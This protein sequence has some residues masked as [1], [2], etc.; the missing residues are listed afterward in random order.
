MGLNVRAFTR[1]HIVAIA[2]GVL[3]AGTPLIAFN[4]WLGG[5]IE[6]QGQAETEAAARRMISLGEQRVGEVVR[7][8]D[9]LAAR[10]VTACDPV[11]AEAMQRAAFN[12]APIKEVA[13]V[14]RGGQT[15]C[16]H[17]NV[18]LADAVGSSGTAGPSFD[19]R[20]VL[21]SEALGG[22]GYSLDVIGFGDGDRMVRLRHP[23]GDG[24][25]EIAA[26]MPATFL[27]P[28]ATAKSDRLYSY[29]HVAT[30]AGAAIGESGERPD[31]ATDM[32]VATR[33]S[34]KFGFNVVVMTQ[35]GRTIAGNVDLKWLGLFVTVIVVVILAAFGM[36]VPKSLPNNPVAE[37]ERALKAG[38]FVPYYQPIVD[39]QSGKLRG[40]E[41]LVRW[42]KPDGTLVLPGSFIP[43]AESSGLIRAMTFDLMRRV[44]VEAGAAIGQRPALKISFNFAGA[45]FSDETIVRDVGRTFAGTPIKLS[46][47][48]LEVTERDPIENFT[49]TRQVI[50]A[51]Q[52]LGVR[53]AIDDVGTGH[54]GLSYML[55]LGVDIIK[56]DK[57][58]VDAIGTD[59]NS[60]TI[61]ETLV[62]LAH[63]MRMDV[64]AEGVENFEQVMHL[65]N[66]GVRSAQGYVFAPP[67]PGS[68]FLQLIEAMDTLGSEA[69]GSLATPARVA[70]A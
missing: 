50:A 21:S 43:L 47:V 7:A 13:I 12:T 51:L 57:M 22:N 35:R 11:N 18:S 54:S 60:T 56:I 23:A 44:C 32:F 1:Q 34:D 55:K 4:F 40:A 37:L 25:N 26:L 9:D 39:I 10:G 49:L 69:E 28:Q 63:N 15:L 16:T 68:S 58:F 6:R 65:R 27:L 24:P 14:A 31:D 38:E 2:V 8:L 33:R 17:F 61:V 64:V 62:D 59:R 48:V 36:M 19:Q 41:V 70:A 30:R 67:L 3:V 66:L 45:L 20:R 53:I 5:V 42:R 46:Q 29:I 52:G